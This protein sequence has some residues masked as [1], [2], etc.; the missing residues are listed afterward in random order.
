MGK[1]FKVIL[2]AAG[3]GTRM[4]GSI[5]KPYLE[6]GSRP[7]L[8]YSLDFFD[9]LDAVDEIII[10]T[11]ANEVDFCRERIINQNQYKKISAVITGGAE[12][13]DSVWAGLKFLQNKKPE[14]V[15]VHD[16]VRPFLFRDLLDKLY[17]EAI[18][19]GSAIPGIRSKDTI[20][21]VDKD[22]FVQKTPAREGLFSIQTPQVFNYKNLFK[23][24]Q[25]AIAENYLGTD[26]A[27]L[28]EKYIGK[29]KVVE[30]Q[31][32]NLKITTPEDLVWAQALM[33]IKL[34]QE[35]SENNLR[36]GT[37]YDVHRLVKGCKLI[38]GGVDI[39][40]ERGLL[41]HSDADVLVHA[42][43]DA[44][45]G[46][47]ALGDIGQH[48]P[49]S[50]EEYRGISSMLLLSKVNQLLNE[51]NYTI[52]NIDSTIEAQKPK[53]NTYIPAM[54]EN[55][56]ICLGLPLEKISIKAT[57]TEGLGMVGREE[58]IAAQAVVLL[59]PINK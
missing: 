9:K 18:K 38:L 2:L 52:E 10:V 44:L 51:K 25:Q 31:Y 39:T 27:M 23:A 14:L 55:L 16:G 56:A 4:G 48:F 1:S 49:N 43:C 46:A 40:Y 47:A 45:L 13:Q 3:R 24:Y 11:A 41:G 57:T 58:G 26:D 28:Y 35:E 7:I 17:T 6:I 59:S 54:R 37:G 15:A 53:L 12:R 34:P 8:N 21:V 30:T 32:N 29:V 33:A 19:W 5:N 22:Y 50:A 20:K 42:I 36:I